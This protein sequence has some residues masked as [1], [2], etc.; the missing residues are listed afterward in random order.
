[1]K[2]NRYTPSQ[3]GRIEREMRTVVEAARSG[4]HAKDLNEK[5]WAEAVN[6]AVFTINQTGTSTVEGKSLAELWFGRKI[7]VIKLKSFGCECYV[8]IEEHKRKKTVKKSE[9]GIFVGYNLDSSSYRIYVSSIN[10][11]KSSEEVIFQEEVAMKGSEVKFKMNAADTNVND[12]IERYEFSDS[13]SSD[14][15]SYHDDLQV[16]V[17]MK[18]RIEM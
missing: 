11:V 3:N 15:Q 18:A 17:E 8:L 7:D 1:M 12:D 13:N 10:D 6:Y 16:K 5:L 14:T 2:S 4:I 9:K